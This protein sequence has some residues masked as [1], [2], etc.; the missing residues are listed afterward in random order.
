MPDYRD[1]RDEPG[2]DDQGTT[3]AAS[4]SLSI[5]RRVLFSG[6]FSENPALGAL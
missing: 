6:N 3:A 1:G 2:H 5:F 4:F